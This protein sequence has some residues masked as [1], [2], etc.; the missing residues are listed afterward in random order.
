[1]YELWQALERARNYR[2]VELS[3]PLT[4]DSPYWA[5]IP[6]GSVEL[7]KTVY[8]WGNPML[9]C[10]IQTFKVPG[11]FGTHIDFPGH[12]A[13]DGA[14]SEAYG[15]G[16]LVFPLCVVDVTEKVEQDVH[17]AVTA[18]DIRDYEVKYGPIPDGA[19]VALRT[20]WSRC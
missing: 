5:G 8:D 1:M 14:L 2:W 11:Q 17:Y 12:F 4:N 16:E 10:L 3:H 18:Q 20:G 6:E 9:D 7:S 19:F 13:K 15:A